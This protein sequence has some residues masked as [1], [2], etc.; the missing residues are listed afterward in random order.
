MAAFA[1]TS[2]STNVTVQADVILGLTISVSP[3]ALNYGYVVAGSTPPLVLPAKAGVPEFTITGNPGSSVYFGW[4]G[5]ISL[6]GP[7]TDLIFTPA[8]AGNNTGTQS[9]STT[10]SSGSSNTYLLNSPGGNYYVW[11]GGS[12]A[13]IPSNQTVGTY[14]GTLT[15]T[16]T[17]AGY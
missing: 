9:G 10:I 5:T 2:A 11:L 3:S 8:F 6:T 4:S 12:L 7:G 15:L 14:S 17:Y 16:V 1:Q 13:A